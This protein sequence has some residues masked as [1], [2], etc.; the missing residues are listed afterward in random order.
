MTKLTRLGVWQLPSGNT[1]VV[2]LL[3]CK[4]CTLCGDGKHTHLQ[5]NWSGDAPGASW[6]AQDWSAYFFV[7]RPAT[8][9][10]ADEMQGVKITKLVE[11]FDQG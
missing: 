2:N 5:H 4:V 9:R 1:C 6:S 7:I 3:D 10:L 8:L 11:P